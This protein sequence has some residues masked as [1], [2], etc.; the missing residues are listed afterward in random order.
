VGALENSEFVIPPSPTLPPQ[1]GRGQT[2]RVAEARVF[3]ERKFSDSHLQTHPGAFRDAN[4]ARTVG[5]N[6]NPPIKEGVGN[7]GCRRHPQPRV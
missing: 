5:K 3:K 4:R 6:L 1:G 7:A 2:E